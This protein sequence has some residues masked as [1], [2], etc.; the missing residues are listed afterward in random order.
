MKRY[1]SKWNFIHTNKTLIWHNKTFSFCF[2]LSPTVFKLGFIGQ[3]VSSSLMRSKSGLW[4]LMINPNRIRVRE[5]VTGT[6]KCPDWQHPWVWLGSLQNRQIS[7][8]VF[9]PYFVY[10][11]LPLCVYVCLLWSRKTPGSDRLKQSSVNH[12]RLENIPVVWFIDCEIPK[13]VTV[14]LRHC[15]RLAWYLWFMMGTLWK[16]GE[17]WEC[18]V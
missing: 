2:R 10:V 16:E 1:N 18:R 4:L 3:L 11:C 8:S 7:L 12:H 13:F 15:S 17:T 9:P 6:K 14:E 5:Y